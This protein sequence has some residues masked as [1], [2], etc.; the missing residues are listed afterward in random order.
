MQYLMQNYG[1]LPVKFEKGTGAWLWDIDGKKYLDALCGI[2]VTGVGHA[3]PDVN[4]A[5]SK[6]L[7]KLSHVSNLYRIEEQEELAKRICTLSGLE[8]AFFCNSGSEA[9]EAAIKIARLFG[10]NRGIKHPEILVMEKAWHGRSLATLTATGSELAQKGFGPLVPGFIRVPYDNSKTLT[11]KIEKNKNIVAVM[12]EPIQGEAGIKI[13]SS[14]YLTNLR[15]ICD[16]HGILLIFDEVQTGMGRTGTWFAYQHTGASPDILTIAKGLGNGFPIGACI[17]RG[18]AAQL[19]GPG[20]HGTTFGGNPVGCAAALAVF[21]VIEKNDLLSNAKL[22]GN[23]IIQDLKQNLKAIDGVKEIRGKALMIAVEMSDP[24][25]SLA[26]DALDKN[27]LINV[28][29]GNTV[30]LLPPLILNESEARL[31]AEKTT[32]VICSTFQ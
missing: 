5:I 28:T 19:F 14:E 3:H 25:P 23:L 20:S 17:A 9:N 32:D 6:Q 13:P 1:R 22:M 2:A 8:N 29:G 10:H 11:E 21:S 27:I 4:R 30:R 16:D 26:L 24:C 12:V 31:V 18:E 15:K 7:E